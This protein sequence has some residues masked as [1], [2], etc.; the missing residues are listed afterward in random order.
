M[1]KLFIFIVYHLPNQHKF[2]V[3]YFK[4]C[5]LINMC[6]PRR[7][8]VQLDVAKMIFKGPLRGSAAGLKLLRQDPVACYTSTTPDSCCERRVWRGTGGIKP[9]VGQPDG[10]LTLAWR[11]AATAWR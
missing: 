4:A 1:S 3:L 11:C 6:S 2:F 9:R 8:L 7:L 10:K 5:V